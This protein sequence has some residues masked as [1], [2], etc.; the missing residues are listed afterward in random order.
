MFTSF[1][2]VVAGGYGSW[3]INYTAGEDFDH[4]QGGVVEIWI[5]AGWTPPQ[6]SSP[7]SNGYVTFS[8][9]PGFI[10]SVTT[11]GQ[12]IRLRIGHPGAKFRAGDV[13]GIHYGSGGPPQYGRV[14]TSAPQTATLL[15]LDQPRPLLGH[16]LTA[17]TSGSPNVSIV[18]DVVTSVRIVDA[19]LVDV[20]TLSR[21]TDQDTT[22]LYL[23]GYDQ[24]ANSARWVSGAW[25]LS[26][27]IGTPVPASGVGTI[28]SLATVGT[29]KAYADSGA[30]RDSTGVITVTNGAYAS[31]ALTSAATATAGTPF[32]ATVESRD[33]DGNRITVGTGSAAPTRLVAYT[34]SLGSTVADPSITNPNATLT[35][36]LWSG[37]KTSQR[38]GTFFIAA[39]DTLT[40][41]TSAPRR[42]LVVAAAPPDHIVASPDTLR[43]TAGFADTV[44]VVARD[45]FQN[46]SPFPADE[47][48][49]LWTDRPQGRFENLGG[50]QIF[51]L[52]IPAGSDS[53]RV[54]FIDT[55]T[56]GAA[57]RIRAI[58]ANGVA[59]FVGTAEAPVF[60]VPNVPVGTVALAAAPASLTADGV[61]SSHV[62]ALA[63][64]DAFSNAVAAGERFT[65]T[66]SGLTV[67]TDDDPG[68]PGFQWTAAPGG[69]LSGWVRA[70]TTAGSATVNVVSERGSATGS[71]GITLGPGVPSGAIALTTAPDSLAADG[72][73]TRTVTAS[74]LHDA[75]SNVVVNGEKYTVAS[76]LGSITTSDADA[77]TPGVQVVASGGAISFTLL[78]GSSLGTATVSATSVRGTSTGS[79]DVRLVPGGVNADS[80]SVAASSPVAVGSPGSTVTVTLRD[81]QGHALAGVPS[82]SIVVSAS[83]V[84]TTRTPLA[85]ATD[86]AGAI[87]YSVTATAVG[88]AVV[89]VTAR[90]VS[91]TA[92]RTVQ[93]V[94]GALDTLIVTGPAGPLT[95]GVSDSLIVTAR[96]AF[97]NG[98]PDR[99][100]L[101]HATVLSGA[102]AGLPTTV[103]LSGGSTVIYFTPTAAS[104][105]AIQVADD[106]S[107]ATAYGPVVVRS[108]APYQL[109]ADPLATD[110]LQVGGSVPVRVH[111][112][113]AY[114]N[115]ADGDTAAASVV[116]GGGNVIPGV[117]LTDGSGAA[118]FA[119][120]AGSAPGTVTLR[121]EATGST[122][123][124]AVRSDS[125]SVVVVSSVV[126]T[127][128]IAAGDTVRAG[129]FLD[130]TL[131][132]RDALGNVA[133]N[134]TPTLTLD[135]STSL[136]DSISWSLGTGASGILVDNGPSDDLATY[137]FTASDSGT[138]SLRVRATRAETI[139]IAISGAGA[140]IQSGN[141]VVIPATATI[142]TVDPLAADTLE[143]GGSVPVRAHVVDVY[144]NAAAGDTVVASVVVGVGGVVPG[145]SVIDASGTGD[146]VLQAGPTPSTV[147]LRLEATGSTAPDAVRSD[148][149][150]VVVIPHP[151]ASV[152]IVAGD[153]LR[154]GDF[155]D[156]TLILRDAFGN[157]AVNATP[158][159]TLDTSTSLPDSISWALG[160]GA[161]GALVDSS[162]SDDVATYSFTAADA[163][164]A[165]LRVRATRAE[166]IRIT[167]SGAGAPVPSGNIAVIPAAATILTADPLATDTL[168]A[169]GSVPVRAHVVDVYGNAAVGATVVASVVVGGGGVVPA[170]DSVD[171]SGAADFVLQAGA[172]PGTVT[173][174]LEATGSTS[175]DAVRSDS[176][177]VVVIPSSV[178]SMEI[179]A[180]DT[181]RAGDFLDFTVTLRDAF[182]NVATGGTATLT[183]D[184]STSL[185]DSISW[186]LGTGASGS[187]VD[188]GPSD[189]L[190]TYTFA[191]ADAGNVAL[192]VRATKAETIRITVSGAGTPVQ[193][194]NIVV[195]PATAM[196]LAILSGQG[197]TAVVNQELALPFRVSARDAFQNLVPGA[198]VT[199]GVV[200]GGG[201]VDAVRGGVA[202][203]TSVTNGSGVAVC[204]VARVGTVA[205]ASNN[206]FRAALPAP[207]DSVFF[208]ASAAPD[209]ATTIT[210]APGSLS[211]AASGSATVTATARDA[212]GN[213]A[214]GTS[215]TFY[216]G[217]PTAGLLA[218]LGPT[219]GS[220]TTQVGL[221]DAAGQIPV[222]YVAPATA[223]ASDVIYARGTTIAPVSINAT[224]SPAGINSLVVLPDAST[225]TVGVPARVVVRALDAGGNLATG[226]SATIVMGA[227]DPVAF[228]PAFG[229]LSGGQFVTFATATVADTL[230]FTAATA[231]GTPSA[232]SGVITVV[233]SSPAGGIPIAAGRTQL[234]AD[235]RSSTNLTFG[236][237]HDQY[238]NT[239]PVGTLLTISADSLLTSDASAAPGIQ[240][241]TGADN[242]ARAILVA[243]FAAALDTVRAATVLGA[244]T[245]QLAVE[246]LAPPSLVRAGSVTPSVVAPGQSYAFAVDV[247]N[248]ASSG[249]VMIGMSS[250]FT[251]GAGAGAFTASPG[252]TL[253]V[254]P[255]ATRTLTMAA[256][257]VSAS[258]TPGT[259]APS[260]RLIGTD[261]TGDAFDFFLSLAGEQ[262]HVAGI[263][264]VAV[265]AAPDPVPL[266]YAA[267]SLTFR[268]DNLAATAA[269]INAVA[270]APATLTVTGTAPALPAALPALG[271]T[272]VTLTVSVPSSGIPAGS[273]V[274]SDLA[275]SASY[276]S[277]TVNAATLSP[278]DFQ[279]VSGAALVAQAAGT[280]PAR[281]L[282][283]RTF[284]PTAR[285]A[286]TG[287][288]AV[289]LTAGATRLVL[290][291]AAT[292]LETG[293]AANAA[294]TG[295]GTANLAFDSLAV[296]AVTPLG[297]YAANLIL[298]GTEAG[299]AFTDTI[300]L[301]PDSVDVLEPAILAVQGGVVPDTVS[302]GQ[303]RPLQL[304]VA[305]TGG[306]PFV[307]GGATRLVLGA[308]VSIT[309]APTATGSVP[310]GG[311]L[312]LT[313]AAAPLGS[314]LAPGTAAGT[315]E[316][317]GTEDGR[318]RDEALGAGSLVAMSPAALA[319]VAASTVPDTVR[320]GQTIGVTCTIQNTGGSPFTLDP[321][322]TRLVIT[323]GVESAV[324]LGAGAPFTLAPTATVMVTFPSV[325][326]PAALASQ[327]Y[328]VLLTVYGTEWGQAESL[329]VASQPGEILVVQ[330]APAV[331]VRS[332]PTSVPV[333]VA[334]G[335]APVAL[336]ALELQPLVPPGG[337]ASA[338]LDS[339]SFTVLVDGSAGGNPSG[340]LSTI[341]LRNAQGALLAQASP[342]VTNPVA[343]AL[344]T[345]LALTGP[346]ESLYVEV[347]LA[348]GT[349]VNSVAL[350][351]AADTDLAVRDDLTGGRV[352]ITGAGGLPF[353]PL[354]SPTVTLFAKAHGYPNPFHVGRED[355]RL[356]YRL[357]GDASVR[358]A[359]YTLLGDL[360]REISLAA[361]TPGGIQ[362]LNEVPWDGR[363]GNGETVRPG[364]Y[365]AQIEGGGVSE[366]IKVGVLR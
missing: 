289:T 287:S 60:T 80:S 288:A 3:T 227:T 153:T 187:L 14:S 275:A 7:V 159:V 232:A 331:Q 113:D 130:F 218:S 360:V 62:T 340:A 263:R 231:S 351:L 214:P 350:R 238:G 12:R 148:S 204:E 322:S 222:S 182:G 133:V 91:L 307:L 347:V 338:H 95:A 25:S 167:V 146:F 58:D 109:T 145:A 53:A 256:T 170:A 243:P 199:F 124:D 209:A 82:D 277:V 68:T 120:Q 112:V 176:V 223:P 164:S 364:V 171:A 90:G 219:S 266:G 76:T 129:G 56:T 63:V 291:R 310:A 96:D 123:P 15:V 162:P 50:V 23:R 300:P 337:S 163:S 184:T 354:T 315:L 151:V 326:F 267:L 318:A 286:N 26:G 5:P 100:D 242:F 225:W 43:L 366:R 293:L 137:T 156:F 65:V 139:R 323:D 191:A 131:T 235:G 319:Y 4:P 52:T 200:A 49:T 55:Q 161:S 149:V 297:R 36:G 97:G 98:M 196:T 190:A 202:D 207:G 118:D 308:P 166:T 233:P 107:H 353:S 259:Y 344:T 119:L 316:A 226:D 108:G 141:I 271:S 181:L 27:G 208:D 102:A 189:D 154:A 150:S 13:V 178:S 276:G 279:V 254:Q 18:P 239:S 39:R 75:F 234:T 1:N 240:V 296:P 303:T 175:P 317:H 269:M 48:L 244:A 88:S 64:R 86:A 217:S 252:A 180:G 282:R 84:A 16:V 85:S 105:L 343:M 42:R 220:G 250:A 228:S 72:I 221:T 28:L 22:H 352:P 294:V 157:V 99:T 245:G 87:G 198:T 197:Q 186:A 136:P 8:D 30:W 126:S 37:T 341:T 283:G 295:S 334:S 365:V 81:R 229:S 249:A 206:R 174:R 158:T 311:T 339:V 328:P 188:N 290:M 116:M 79:T 114:G 329:A 251:F 44:T 236:P 194:G 253:L 94:H 324:A 117:D 83:G 270:L 332:L 2:P 6:T 57:G 265:G 306:V 19:A 280:S 70:G 10:D 93:F 69:T 41:L 144:G 47:E 248:T 362:G 346:A 168:L 281:Y 203:P 101:V 192:R 155:L 142:L 33:S 185:P 363:N 285:V 74:G 21:T 260:L 132:L 89:S 92:S 258:L 34:D 330:P 66:G 247:T 125:V 246:Y 292:R 272:T 67:I 29:G 160:P 152:E 143:V 241:A 31:L 357:A 302:A 327:P 213:A 20:T 78:G 274:S 40:A 24:Y 9:A 216:L 261:A 313:F 359:I 134:A 193:S 304:T 320:A 165:A 312:A 237:V 301:A 205:G 262:V 264:V 11:S 73:A 115:A 110:T 230:R 201:S 305:N 54:R 173:L 32:A 51:S 17:L 147:T 268:V 210:L 46:R 45:V 128:Q 314:P 325:T 361:G 355:V 104:P 335:G 356:S 224:V 299:L 345:P 336:W 111:V 138:V 172:A 255:G 61:D 257:A 135:T 183:L 59:P 342:G 38:S 122:A 127:V 298:V 195:I 140:P 333:Q 215:I 284:G 309:L 77:G 121:L 273:T 358:V 321:A 348:S 212:F 179:S 177:S 278:L 106:S 103:A 349:P 169:G 35:L 211:L 71:V